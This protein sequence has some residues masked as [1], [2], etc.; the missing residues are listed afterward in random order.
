VADDSNV[1]KELTP[2]QLV[3]LDEIREEWIQKGLNTERVD[4]GRMELAAKAAYR[5]ADLDVPDLVVWCDSPMAGAVQV[6]KFVF[7]TED[8]TEEQ[9]REQLWHAC[10]GQHE[11]WVAFYSAFLEFGVEEC[12]PLEPYMDLAE[13]GWWW[14]L[15]EA[16]VMVE[17]PVHVSTDEEGRLH[18][19]DRAAIEWSD[20][21]GVYAW[22]GAR[23]PKEVI[24]EP[25]KITV[26]DIDSEENAEVRR[27]MLTR[28]GEGRYLIDSGAEIL[29]EDVD[30]QGH[31]RKLYKKPMEAPEE[32]IV[33]VRVI[34]STPEPDGSRNIYW[35]RVPPHFTD[36]KAAVAWTFEEDAESYQPEVE[37]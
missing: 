23:V 9:A 2:A 22:H 31:E 7:E 34:N 5:I 33:M 1:I 20:G 8:I 32:D 14:P 29:D 6:A 12:R 35:L 10:Y 4:R 36:V 11:S 16:I 30:I 18:C 28:Y 17:R 21:W 27:V 15:D 25:E 13:S 37:T 24:L 3:R 19:E 26:K